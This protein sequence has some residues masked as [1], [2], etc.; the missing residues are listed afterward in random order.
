[1]R[2]KFIMLGAACAGLGVAFGAFGAHG[3]KT[4]L[5]PEM[6]DAYKTAVAY[7]LWHAL[8]LCV[9]GLLHERGGAA[10]LL[11][12]SGGLML[13]GIVLFSGSLYLLTILNLKWLGMITPFGGVAFIIAWLL[14][15]IHAAQSD[16]G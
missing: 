3:L 16:N 11:Q 14:L 7:H 8:G 9:V 5:T 2:S 6:L 4:L 12:W 10:R 1:M 13:A 15:A